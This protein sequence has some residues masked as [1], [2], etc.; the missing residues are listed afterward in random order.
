MKTGDWETAHNVTASMASNNVWFGLLPIKDPHLILFFL[1]PSEQTA[2]ICWWHGSEIWSESAGW[3]RFLCCGGTGLQ[4]D[5]SSFF[6]IRGVCV[7]NTFCTLFNLPFQCLG[8]WGFLCRIPGSPAKI[9]IITFVWSCLCPVGW[10]NVGVLRLPAVDNVDDNHVT[11]WIRC[12]PF[13]IQY[14]LAPAPHSDV[15]FGFPPCLGCLTGNS[16]LPFVCCLIFIIFMLHPP[17]PIPH[18][19]QQKSFTLHCFYS[20]LFIFFRSLALVVF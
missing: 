6:V 16:R 7:I 2:N 3:V 5:F 4:I 12:F 18:T 9:S 19:C 15:L 1:V 14:I 10:G 17:Y 20:I 8:L 13:H 11:S